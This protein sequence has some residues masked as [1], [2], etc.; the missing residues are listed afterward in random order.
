M[1]RY[2]SIAYIIA[3]TFIITTIVLVISDNPAEA[4]EALAACLLAIPVAIIAYYGMKKL[5]TKYLSLI[6]I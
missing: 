6:H 5:L 1:N 3:I 2:H 4:F